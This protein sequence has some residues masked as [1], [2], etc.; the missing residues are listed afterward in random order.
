[1]GTLGGS[2]SWAFRIN[3]KGEVVGNS[4]TMGD[5]VAHSFLTQNGTM[6][7]LGTTGGYACN[8]ALG[9]NASTQIVGALT[10][11]VDGCAAWRS[12]F[13]WEDGD[14][15]DLNT[16]IPSESRLHLIAAFD[17]TERGEIIGQ[18]MDPSCTDP[19]QCDYLHTFLLLPCD[20]AH[21]SIEGCNYS[22]AE[23]NALLQ[24][25][26]EQSTSRVSSVSLSQRVPRNRMPWT[27][28]RQY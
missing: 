23:N 1:L 25:S 19:D 4:F 24:N 28:R 20:D 17:I 2:D 10:S 26:H 6:L 14:M 27:W 12:A 5:E 21:P 13:L 8:V 7:D 11:A 18:G 22:L 16:L 15:V 9:I 3:D